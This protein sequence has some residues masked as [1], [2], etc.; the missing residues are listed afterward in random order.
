MVECLVNDAPRRLD[1]GPET[2]GDLLKGLD[3]ECAAGRETV[4]AVRF[5]GVDQ[6]SFRGPDAAAHSLARVRRI[7]IEVVDRARLLRNTLGTAGRS[8]PSLAAAAGR[9]GQAFRGH[10]LVDAHQQLTSLVE[11]IRTLTMLTAAS[12][13]A[14]GADL[15]RLPCGA[16]TAADIL[17]AVGVVLDVLAQ[18]QQGSDW[19]A[20]ADAME[21][22]LAPTLLEWGV[23]FDAIQ[24][25]CAA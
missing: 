24:D 10:D 12:A 15:E 4:T 9:V 19:V 3:E 11:A 13:S 17:G 1:S 20:V 18:G 8:L 7:D 23:V 22:D 16:G 5:D 21:L 25:R 2:W 14:A 6:P